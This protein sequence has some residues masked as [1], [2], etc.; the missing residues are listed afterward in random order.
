MV[1]ASIIQG[2]TISPLLF[3]IF[4]N[5]M[6]LFISK[7]DICN[8]TDNNTINLCGKALCD[9]SRNL[10]FDSGRALQ[11]LKVNS[12]KSNSGK[13]QFMILTANTEN[14]VKLTLDG[15]KIKKS[16]EVFHLRKKYWR[17][18][19]MHIQNIFQTNKYK[20]TCVAAGKK[21]FKSR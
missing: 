15:N 10:K 5:D 7:A 4:V 6:F 1:S 8:F 3:N 19:K 9:T 16:Q 18:F 20:F 11:W 12:L 14:K 2:S 17:G 13:F 21:A